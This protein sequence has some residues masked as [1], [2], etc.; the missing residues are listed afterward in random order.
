[1]KIAYFINQY[2]R[3]SHSFIRREI[4]AVERQGFTVQ[5][6]A[7][8]GW[9]DPLP[10]P[11]DQRER[12]RTQYV[13]RGGAWRLLAAA[14]A[15]L[16]RSP[17]RFFGALSLAMSMAHRSYR[18][19]IYHLINL[20]EACRV[21]QWT[22]AFGAQ[23]IHA[24]FGTNSAEV[25]ML[26]SALG[27]PPFS[28]TVH[29]PEEFLQPM[30]LDRKVHHSRFA[31][32]ISSFGRS[33]LLLCC[34]H[35]EWDRIKI[36]HCGLEPEYFA[37]A[38]A[39][40]SHPKRLICVG[41]LCEAKGQLLL[42]EA[43]AALQTRGRRVELV[44]A[45][46]GPLRPELERLIRQHG[47]EHCIRITGW[48]GSSAVR[49]EILAARALVLPS[50]AEGLPVVI[51]EAMAL[52][53]PVLSTYIAGIPE[54]VVPGE[55]G[56]LFPAGSIEELIGSIEQCLSLSDADLRS[57]GEA[58]HRRVMARHNIDVEAKRLSGLFQG[59]RFGYTES[60]A[61]HLLTV[62]HALL[63]LIGILLLLPSLLLAAE[64]A[65]SVSNRSGAAILTGPRGQLA[66]VVPAH[67]EAPI[68]AS[69]LRSIGAQLRPG[70]RLLVVADNCS[71]GTGAVA[72]AEGA[73]VIVRTD[74]LRRGKGYALDF[75]VQAL[76]SSA[77]TIVLV[78]D[79][80]CQ[81]APGAVEQLARLCSATGRPVQAL[82]RLTAPVGAP[83]M[84]RLKE[85][86]CAVKNE[87]R[88]LGLHRV[89]LPCQLMGTG[90]AF[91]WNAIATAKLATGQIVEDLQLGIELT[92]AG[93]APLLCP[94]AVVSSELPATAE[95]LESQRARWEHGHLAA[96]AREG[97][98]LLFGSL[99]KGD[100]RGVALAADLMVPPLA[101]LLLL[102]AADC[103]ASALF[104]VVAGSLWPL[105]L[106][107]AAA[108]LL[109][110]AV[111]LAWSRYGR[112]SL[113]LRSLFLA[114]LYALAK[115]PLYLRFFR[116][117]QQ[118]WVRSRRDHE[119]PDHDS[120]A[121]GAAT[122]RPGNDQRQ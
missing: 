30:G 78:V 47:L 84:S 91:P 42:I 33:Q 94:A 97:P 2:P 51:M 27:G 73:E 66:V 89:G 7:L 46:D 11:D 107:G 65:L 50:F 24:H 85:F 39:G 111:L 56:W 81:A 115:T 59:H 57:M 25:P 1:M 22:R 53:R 101:L 119:R 77:P 90:M 118:Q 45:G 80:D 121:D 40:A 23:H 88:A 17:P 54:L 71:D 34:P 48:I 69:T 58:G 49:A 63:L 37:T 86:A 113:P 112:Q 67:N 60:F 93:S 122:Q 64:I 108:L 5:R 104:Y 35:E 16:V 38:W 43:I 98:S 87:A 52:R 13:L 62:L 28:F 99:G 44:L 95:G 61:M 110:L 29:G 102:I 100:W 72:A 92:R 15:T 79:A 74:A 36:V 14:A 4:L 26:V 68:I 83:L 21:L 31:V 103:I 18:P 12:E 120:S 70:D 117:R 32:A 55:T 3:V 96:I 41:R 10:D 109:V 20:L 6:I 116:A 8:R 106:G 76:A 9:N 75:A 82:Y 19:R 114:P 105:L